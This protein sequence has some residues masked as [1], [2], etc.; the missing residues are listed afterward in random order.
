ML[1]KIKKRIIPILIIAS[2]LCSAQAQMEMGGWRTEFSYTGV[3]QLVQTKDKVYAL[4]SGNLYS[5]DKTYNSLETYSKL[6]GLSDGNILMAGYS[7]STNLLLIC[8]NNLNIDLID[9]ATTYNL[10]ELK[11]KEITS[12][13]LNNIA[14]DGNYA[15][16][17][18]GFGIV[19]I[20]LQ[21]K[22]I[23]NT[24][25]IG[26]GGQYAN[27]KQ[28]QVTE[29]SIYALTNSQ[30]C[31]AYK[32]ERN[33]ADYNLW[34]RRQLP[35]G[36][37]NTIAFFGGKMNLFGDV[38][39]TW[40]EGTGWSLHSTDI[41]NVTQAH[42]YNNYLTVQSPAY[43]TAVYD[44][45][46]NSDTLFYNSGKDAVYDPTKKEI[47]VGLD[48]LYKYAMDGDVENKFCPTGP[49][50][51]DVSFFK[52]ENGRLLSGCG[53]DYSASGVVQVKYNGEW[54][55]I[56]R[57]D[58]DSP[59]N[60]LFYSIWDATL[61]PRD[62][63]RML[64]ATWRGLFEFYN[65]KFVKLYNSSNSGLQSQSWSSDIVLCDGVMFDQNNFLWVLNAQ[66]GNLLKSMDTNNS[67][68]SIGYTQ[69][70]NKATTTPIFESENGYKWVLCPRKAD[71]ET[72]GTGLF[73]VDD[74]DTPYG[75]S[76]D[77]TRWMSYFSLSD[78][79]TYTPNSFRCIA[80]D[81][82]ND[83]WIGT[84]IGPFILSNTANIFNSSYTAQ[85]IKIT[86]EDNTTLADYL[87]STEQIN[88]IAVDGANRKWVATNTSGVYLLS[89]D[90]QETIHHF[91]TDNSPLTT[92]DIT[93]LALNQ[94]NGEVYIATANGMFVYQSDAAAGNA[95][96][97]NIHVYPN[98]V[99]PDFEGQITVA[100]LMEDCE[101]RIT[102]LE[103]HVICHGKS[104]GGLY[105]WDGNLSD[106]ERAPTGVYFVFAITKDG[107]TKN[108]TKFAIIDR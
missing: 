33:L 91:T 29:D 78:G 53:T 8:Y 11:N 77:K 100:G 31:S 38:W 34:K 76:D 48:S 71:S 37:K 90:G 21:K 82:N 68:H 39:Y 95:D 12:K 7:E 15:Y 106:G 72:Y 55:V 67:W 92:D 57:E 22:E 87:L 4:C 105:A 69:L 24:Y 1:Q 47:W 89:D 62:A 46:Y 85:R 60:G 65:N 52:Y 66:S 59:Y 26:E 27:I 17:S 84:D 58:L 94:E 88:A 23:A 36:T 10:S 41:I 56:K 9:G 16:L 5:V 6:T 74:N 32:N 86:R 79:N 97:E 61:D 96:L 99:K 80:E 75:T 107:E 28:V 51:N 43:L 20:N 93:G 35:N 102:D 45:N 81:K 2:S 54:S 3:D 42:I 30:L 73:V 50:V 101:I 49:Y 19:V 70:Y 64:V 13:T 98:P 63:K 44:E 18:C 14:F 108:V 104:N 40:E 103:G 25:I 83:I